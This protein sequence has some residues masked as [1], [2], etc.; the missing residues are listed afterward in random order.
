MSL[1]LIVP[2]AVIAAAVSTAYAVRRSRLGLFLAPLAVL[3]TCTGGTAVSGDVGGRKVLAFCEETLRVRE[4]A[5]AGG[6][7]SLDATAAAPQP[8]CRILNQTWGTWEMGVF[9]GGQQIGRLEL[10]TDGEAFFV[11][12]FFAGVR[13]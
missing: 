2:A 7:P 1:Y 8:H 13:R 9:S 11:S 6:A 4:S 3:A 10:Q 5:G 12:N